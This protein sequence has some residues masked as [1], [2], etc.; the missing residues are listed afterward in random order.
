MASAMADAAAQRRHTSKTRPVE[1]KQKAWEG[2]AAHHEHVGAKSETGEA[3]V[4]RDD[5]HGDHGGAMI[6][7]VGVLATAVGKTTKQQGIKHHGI[8]MKPKV[9]RS[10][11]MAH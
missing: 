7:G 9:H 11:A 2:S 8:E 3:T 5:V 1:C 6:V 10:R 4:T